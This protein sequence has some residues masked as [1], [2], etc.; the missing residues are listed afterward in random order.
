MKELMARLVSFKYLKEVHL[1]YCQ[2]ANVLCGSLGILNPGAKDSAV[3]RLKIEQPGFSDG[4]SLSLGENMES[5]SLHHCDNQH[6][7]ES[8]VSSASKQKLLVG[9]HIVDC[10]DIFS[11]ENDQNLRCVVP[12]SHQTLK[13][14][15]LSSEFPANVSSVD[16]LSSGSFPLLE[17]LHISSMYGGNHLRYLNQCPRLQL[18]E[19]AHFPHLD[20]IDLSDRTSLQRLVLRKCRLSQLKCPPGLKSLKLFACEPS[21]RSPGHAVSSFTFTPHRLASPDH[22]LRLAKEVLGVCKELDELDLSGNGFE[23]EHIDGIERC[24]KDNERV[25]KSLKVV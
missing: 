6:L 13:H 12:R 4:C 24:L 3:R 22:V 20:I 2:S 21:S 7:I 17:S 18:L 14:L 9:F 5:L 8:F 16:F 10:I 1:L 23:K 25:L 15:S 19:I 11:A